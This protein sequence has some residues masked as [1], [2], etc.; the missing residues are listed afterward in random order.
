MKN[1]STIRY[2]AVSDPADP[3]RMT[4][5][6]ET[7]RGRRSWPPKS[8]TFGADFYERLKAAT[9]EERVHL[10]QTWRAAIDVEIDARPD[11][12]SA[13]FSA[14]HSRC[15]FCGR[16]LTDPTSKTYGIGPEC[17]SGCPD[18]L[19]EALAEQMR[20]TV[21]ELNHHELAHP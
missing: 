4:F 20:R 11:L 9:H 5:W 2:Y 7:E 1:I 21:T 15:S 3:T 6:R 12:A 16:R 18:P 14:W 8:G 19:L 13:R 17:R 10:M